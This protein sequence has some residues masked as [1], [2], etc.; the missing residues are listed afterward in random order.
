MAIYALTLML[1]IAAAA[2]VDW[3]RHMRIQATRSHRGFAVI[4][5]LVVGLVIAITVACLLFAITSLRT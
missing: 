5:V 4:D 2:L 1:V 3:R